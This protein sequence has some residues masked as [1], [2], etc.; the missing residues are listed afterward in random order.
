VLNSIAVRPEIRAETRDCSGAR[1]TNT[2]RHTTEK[3][4]A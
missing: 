1:N 4:L 3:I 2:F